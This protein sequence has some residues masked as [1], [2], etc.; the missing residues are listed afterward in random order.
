MWY[1]VDSIKWEKK[2]IKKNFNKHWSRFY[3]PRRTLWPF[4]T[5][6]V[7]STE[8]NRLWILNVQNLQSESTGNAHIHM[9]KKKPQLYSNNN[10]NMPW[11]IFVT[12]QHFAKFVVNVMRSS[13]Y[14]DW[15]CVCLCPSSNSFYR[16]QTLDVC[17]LWA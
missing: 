17:Y 7:R 9:I 14:I 13:V 5:F 15:M 10:N 8:H 12:V 11:M 3:W 6:C 16:T 2:K 4:L 1:F